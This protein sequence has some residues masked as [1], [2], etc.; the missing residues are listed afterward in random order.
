MP[1]KKC[2]QDNKN[3][4]KWGNSGTCFTGPDAKKSALAVGQASNAQSITDMPLNR[5]VFLFNDFYQDTAEEVV[6]QLIDLDQASADPVY[7]FINSYGG[8]VYSLFS[9]LDTIGSMR[10][11]VN[12]VCLGEADSCGA[13]LLS[14]GEARYIGQRS[15]TMM[16]EV[17]TFTWG[18]ISELEEDLKLAQEVNNQIVEILA[19]N[20]QTDADSLAET[21]KKDT[22]SDAETSV[23]MGLVDFILDDSALDQEEDAVQN[24]VNSFSGHTKDMAL[25]KVMC[26]KRGGGLPTRQTQKNTLNQAKK[27]TKG[28][29]SM[30]LDQM[31]ADL[32][33]KHGIDVKALQ[34]STQTLT[35]A[36][37]EAETRAKTAEQALQ[38]FQTQT[39]TEGIEALLTSLIEQKKSSQ[40][41][42]DTVY[43]AAFTAAGLE[44]A[45]VMADALQ[46]LDLKDSRDSAEPVV[47]EDLEGS[48][49]QAKALDNGI[50]AY[51]KENNID[52]YAVAAEKYIA[53][54]DKKGENA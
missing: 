1:L 26:N 11:P 43:R 25:A 20:M 4:Y 27:V 39:E 34:D 33:S 46:V 40:N 53:I 24:F 23:E 13:V 9:I 21:M 8:A 6:K 35:A 19:E 54:L 3:G 51:M 52:N 45:K 29:T 49:E 47:S 17:S 36:V 37:G 48:N 31:L 15:R 22:F 38:D 28:E 42:N 2:A 44:Q 12:T 41:L 10:A 16:H 5:S 18:K 32:K 50:K 30:T 14:A 7:L